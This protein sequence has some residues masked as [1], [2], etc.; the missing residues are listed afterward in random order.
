MNFD[1][2]IVGGGTAGCVLAN[3]LS[4]DP[5]CRVLLLEAGPRPRGLWTRMPAGTAKM[6]NRGPYNWGYDTEPE[7]ELNNRVVYAPRGK[8]LGGSSLINGMVFVRGQ[9]QDF[10]AWARFGV[11]GWGWS[12]VLPYY[13]KL[14]SR[15]GGDDALRGRGGELSVA[16]PLYRHPSSID[17]VQ[18]CMAVGIPGNDDL[19]G[20]SAEG[21]GFLQFSIDKGLRHSSAEAFLFPVKSRANLTVLTGC[22]ATRVLIKDGNAVGVEFNQGGV[23]QVARA[24]REVLLAS[25]AFGSPMLLMHSGIGPAETLRQHGIVVVADR[26]GVGRNLQD[27]FYINTTYAATEES[28]LNRQLRGWRVMLHGV[29]FLLTRTG[30]LTM[31]ASQ[32]VA[33]ARSRPDAERADLQINFKPVTWERTPTGVVISKVPELTAAACFLHPHSRGEITLRSRNPLD[34][35]VIRANYFSAAE[36]QAAVLASLRLSRRIFQSEPLRSRVKHEVLPGAD[37]RSD[38][39]LIDYVRQFGTS[40]HHWAGSCRVGTDPLAVVNERLAVHGVGRLRVV[41]A[42]VMPLMPSANTNAP[43]Y[44]IAERAADLILADARRLA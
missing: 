4:N 35:P 9:A 15:Q 44:M 39:E 23:S 41:D 3:R 43:T 12:D 25:G 42:S 21:A 36:D 27:H 10:D 17:F 30:P 20:A 19:N 8:G 14:E 31:G 32:S 18:A 38:Q 7:P 37:L 13:R 26:Q 24:H 1:Y 28:S 16:D 29:R 2:I 5:N 34:A 6:F 33:F 40:M 11:R 22:Q